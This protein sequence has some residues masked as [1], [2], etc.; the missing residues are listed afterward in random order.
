MII[1]NIKKEIKDLF[2]QNESNRNFLFFRTKI[3]LN[4]VY[5]QHDDVVEKR[6]TSGVRLAGHLDAHKCKRIFHDLILVS[7]IQK[8]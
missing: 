8:L 4:K 1:Y 6:E 5:L 7:T 2:L 3:K